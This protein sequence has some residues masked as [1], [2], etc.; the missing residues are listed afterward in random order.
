M[1]S[2][3][4]RRD[5][6]YA[7][8]MHGVIVTRKGEVPVLT[9][10][11]SFRGAFLQTA[12]P[13]QLRQLVRLRLALPPE[14]DAGGRDREIVTTGMVAHV[15]AAGDPGGRAPGAG[16]EFYGLDGEL[17]TRWERFIKS[18]Q[19]RLG[20]RE[21]PAAR[22]ADS[23]THAGRGR[24]LDAELVQAGVEAEGAGPSSVSRGQ[25]ILR[26]RMFVRTDVPQSVGAGLVVNLVDPMSRERFPVDCVVR[27]RV[28]GSDAGV[29][30]EILE[31]TPATRSALAEFLGSDALPPAVADRN[32]ATKR[33]RPRATAP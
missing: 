30:V 14:L 16:I 6:R 1:G 28:F 33:P 25:N 24:H 22:R 15:V 20:D 17:R 3:L 10:D 5:R 19:A 29:E 18:A 4:D 7:V 9:G 11:V 2:A 32:A 27:R 8:H 13:P 26:G 21:E 23:E 12:S 31:M